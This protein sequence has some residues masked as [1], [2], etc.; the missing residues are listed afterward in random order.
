MAHAIF[1]EDHPCH[2]KSCMDCETCIFDEPIFDD[3]EKKMVTGLCNEC[4]YLVKKYVFGEGSRCY[5]A[6][7]GKHLIMTSNIQRERV[8]QRGVF[9]N[10][11]I[12]APDWCPKKAELPIRSKET[13]LTLPPPPAKPYHYDELIERRNKMKELPSVY[14]WK[15]LKEGDICVIPTLL[16]QKRKIVVIREKTDY[17]LKCTEL[18]ENLEYQSKVVNIYSNDIDANF[19]VKYHKF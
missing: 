3:N 14:S 6:T 1:N 7:C 10:V 2:G 17:V 4:G 13:Q 11:A 15:D 19:I 8:I 18:N 12:T 5:D 9:G 16:R